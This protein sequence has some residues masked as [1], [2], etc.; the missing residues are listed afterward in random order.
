MSRSYAVALLFPLIVFVSL[1]MP[2]R[3]G[4]TD[5]GFIHIQYANNIIS[6]GEYS[7]NPGET[8]FGTTSPLWV[9]VQAFLGKM[10]G[11]GAAMVTT[12]RVVSWIAALLS[13]VF[14]FLLARKSGLS[15]WVSYFCVLAFATHAW[16]VRW[17]ALGME[18]S[19]AVLVITAAGIASLDAQRNERGAML[20]GFFMAI[21]SLIRPEAYLFAPVYFASVV[22]RGRGARWGL[23]ART[24]LIYGALMIPWLV[25]AKIHIGSF[26]PNTASA[27]SGGHVLNPNVMLAGFESV[28]KIVGSVEAIPVLL[29]VSTL[30]IRRARSV[31]LTPRFCF[32]VMWVIALP[33]AYVL[34]DIQVLSRYMLLISPF[35]F[36]LGFISLDEL[37]VAF[38][39]T[40]RFRRAAVVIMAGLIVVVNATF[41]F[42]VVLPPSR[43]F[44][45]DLTHTLR[46]LAV[47]LNEN[48]E[49]GTV[50]A[51]A[52]IGYLAFYSKR[53]VLDLG[54]LVDTETA[55]LREAHPYE[56]IVDE[57]LYLDLPKYPHV[58]YFIDR[59]KT[60]DRFDGRVLRGYRF[61]KMK[62][63]EI[64]N[65]GIRKP[66]PF[67]YTLYHLERVA[68]DTAH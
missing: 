35:V 32:F 40:I 62:T 52:D 68:D 41:Y 64:A 59:E 53:W 1:A 4:F 28:L 17:S 21:A 65:L 42:I 49:S 58:D 55:K 39:R 26:L 61:R 66:G 29:I 31:L 47:Y 51:A 13:L 46:G 16:F 30:I 50:V 10:L 27:K 24:G 5:D 18:T 48:S 12:S 8:S 7:F 9:M 54:G 67:F 23:A 6:R 37:V 36:V 15:P 11:G 38:H 25:F 57:G 22:I 19:S 43:A 60:A 44:S 20:L 63:V 45:Y 56:E 33:A 34:F 2:L 14:L 3:S